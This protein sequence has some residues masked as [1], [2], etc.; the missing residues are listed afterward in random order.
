MTAKHQQRERDYN[1]QETYTLK[2][3]NAAHKE[4]VY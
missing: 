4:D 3:N 1:Q 2:A